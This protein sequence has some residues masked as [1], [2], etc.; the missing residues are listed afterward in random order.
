V[1]RKLACL[2]LCCTALLLQAC[3]TTRL[4]YDHLDTVLRWVLSD[5]VDIETPQTQ[6]WDQDFPPLWQWH[7]RTQLP[8]YAADLR[9][10]AGEVKAGPLSFPQLQQ[11]ST[12]LTG[13]WHATVEQALPGFAAFCASL[14]DEQTADMVKRIGAKIDKKGRKRDSYNEA[15]RRE[16]L[17]NETDASMRKWLGSINDAQRQ[18]VAQ[19]VQGVQLIGPRDTADQRAIL[20]H[21]EA[22][23]KNRNDPGF[24][25]GLHDLLLPPEKPDDPPSRSAVE[26]DRWL[27]LL[28]EVSATLEPEQRQHLHDKLQGYA[29]DFEALAAESP[30]QQ[31]QQKAKADAR[32]D[33]AQE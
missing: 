25:A 19:W 31:E 6:L 3:S 1:T 30:Q 20:A 12:R 8:Q 13:Y 33:P 16:R 9:R 4:G 28:A 32:A 18:L 10:L 7:R 24:Q 2:L 21:F 11:D 29:E 17:T 14:S 5:Y 26:R 23:M 27:K 22:L 15:E